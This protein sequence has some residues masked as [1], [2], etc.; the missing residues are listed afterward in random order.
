MTRFGN[1]GSNGNGSK[2]LQEISEG[3]GGAHAGALQGCTQTTSLRVV[4]DM[5]NAVMKRM[6]KMDQVITKPDRMGERVEILESTQGRETPSTDPGEGTSKLVR[7]ED[8]DAET[9][10]VLDKFLKD[11]KERYNNMHGMQL[12]E[13]FKYFKNQEVKHFQVADKNYVRGL[14]DLLLEKDVPVRKE[15]RVAVRRVLIEFRDNYDPQPRKLEKQT[16]GES[17]VKTISH[18]ADNTQA[19]GNFSVDDVFQGEKIEVRK[20]NPQT[21]CITHGGSIRGT[22]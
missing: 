19:D 20:E 3:P 4:E 18:A 14:R 6:G 15:V 11:R 9:R 1:S 7:I 10:S 16:M 17:R 2:H 12:F 22:S 13:E 21:K 8:P 5:M